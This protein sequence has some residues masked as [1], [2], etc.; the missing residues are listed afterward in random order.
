MTAAPPV[1]G[2]GVLRR[3]ED[4]LA[5]ALL[6]AMAVL[7]IIEMAA[8]RLRHEGIPG[9]PL[10]VQH[11]TL[12]IAFVGAGLAAR[13]DRLLAL[14]TATYL[15]AAWR[16]RLARVTSSAAALV[17]TVMALA[18]VDLVRAEQA[19]VEPVALGIPAWGFVCVMPVFLV[20]VAWRVVRRAGPTWAW[21]AGLLVPSLVAAV[22]WWLVPEVAVETV[23]A[24]FPA[25]LLALGVVFLALAGLPMFTALGGLA[26]LF[27]FRDGTP[28]A[29]VPV[30][31][32]RLTASPVFPAIPLFTLAGYLLSAGSASER[33][34]R[35]FRACL[36]WLP[37]GPAIATTLTFAFFTCFTGASGVTILSLG[38]LLMPV[39]LKMRYPERFTLGLLTTSGSIGLLFPPSLPVILYGVA[40][41]VPMDKLFLAGIIPG[42][43][44]VAGVAGY[45]AWVGVHEDTLREKFDVRE[46]L[47]ALWGARSELLIP[48]VVLGGIFGGFATLVESAALTVAG[49]LFVELAL[50]RDP[51]FHRNFR[52]AMVECGTLVGGVLMIL[53]VAMGFTN[54]LLDAQVPMTALRW[55]QAHVETRAGFLLAVNLLL[56]LVGAAMDIYSGILVVVPL[57][58]PMAV[59]FGVDPVH[60]GVVFLTNLEL[61]YLLPPVGENLFLSSYRFGKPISEVF[62]AT[63]PFVLVITVVVLL[64]T[65]VPALTW[66]GTR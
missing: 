53:G 34:V 62:R 8:R 11:L 35:L 10:L 56:V 66:L 15:S 30:E 37:G 43:L 23:R 60:L 27:F 24:H 4:I 14:G 12:C 19:G 17:C 40:A 13:E 52:G 21:R 50:H 48:V 25:G 28:L 59:A 32:Y 42:A 54:Y 18:G 20:V 22:A 45:G 51:V 1:V 64:V 49:V 2:R 33:L 63:M 3:A 26:L 58:A 46:A 39:L 6:V 41:Q 7:P 65:Y 36:G 55:V 61:G 44:L 29:A 57:I 9:T 47:A 5:S 31:T 16:A 38:G